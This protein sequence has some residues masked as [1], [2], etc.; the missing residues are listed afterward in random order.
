VAL[1]GRGPANRTIAWRTRDGAFE[2][3]RLPRDLAKNARVSRTVD[4]P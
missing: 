2:A 4:L 3:N 1:L